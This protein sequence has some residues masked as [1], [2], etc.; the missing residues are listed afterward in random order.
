MELLESRTETE[1]AELQQ[2]ILVVEDSVTS[3][4]LMKNILENTGFLVETAFDGIDGLAKIRENEYDV[5]ISDV[6]MPRM[7]G[8]DMTASIRADANIKQMPVIMVTSLNRDEDL[9]KG[10]DAGANDY[11]IKSNFTQS[12]L[13]EIIGNLLK[14]GSGN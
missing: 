7:N 1:T 14:A 8:F 2:R 10:R 13:V 5:V 6:D 9:Q 12:N 3:R 11:I 4:M